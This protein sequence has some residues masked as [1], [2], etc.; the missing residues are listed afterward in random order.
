MIKLISKLL[1]KLGY[2][3]EK[4]R[5]DPKTIDW[6]SQALFK[7]ARKLGKDLLECRY[8]DLNSVHNITV[9]VDTE[10]ED[11]STGSWYYTIIAQGLGGGTTSYQLHCRD[12]DISYGFKVVPIEKPKC[13]GTTPW[14]RKVARNKAKK[15][16]G[17]V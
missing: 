15:L 17:V 6:S 11:V 13:D 2:T 12:Y 8:F 3:V 10:V 7:P 4:K 1:D 5:L 14:E 9:M 16:G